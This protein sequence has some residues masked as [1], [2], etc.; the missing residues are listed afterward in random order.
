MHRIWWQWRDVSVHDHPHLPFI[1]MGFFKTARHEHQKIPQFLKKPRPNTAFRDC[2]LEW[3]SFWKKDTHH[4]V[5]R[6]LPTWPIDTSSC[7]H[8]LSYPFRREF[9][10]PG[11][12][13]PRQNDFHLGRAWSIL[14][15]QI[16][17][18]MHFLLRSDMN[19]T[20]HLLEAPSWLYGRTGPFPINKSPQNSFQCTGRRYFEQNN[21]ESSE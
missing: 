2:A 14:A 15:A 18:Y 9:V 17:D 1:G 19:G 7:F 11:F 13:L 10:E 4:K 6:V 3:G 21:G 8:C 5:Y 20:P 12:D 16:C